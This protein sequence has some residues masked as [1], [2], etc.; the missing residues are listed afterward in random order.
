M[1]QPLSKNEQRWTLIVTILASGIVFLSGSIVNVALPAIGQSLDSGLSGLQWVVDGYL[2][3][4]SSLLIMGGTL[5][6]RFGR[7]QICLIGLVGFG[8]ALTLC[9]L[10]PSINWLIAARAFQGISGALLVPQS[11]SIIR[12]N[13]EDAEKRG[14]AIG[15]WSGWTGI[16]TVIGPLV[17][18]ALVS[19]L[20][21]RWAFLINL[22]LIILTI[23]LMI[24]FVPEKKVETSPQKLDWFGALLTTIGLGGLTFGLIEGPTLGWTNGWVLSGLIGG[25]IMLI[26]FPLFESRIKNPLLPLSLFKSRNF[27]G[28]NLT[29]F[30]VYAA[31]QG[32]TFILI[33]YV[34]N[35]MGYSPLQAGLITAPISLILLLLSSF[36]GK[37]SNQHGPRLFMTFGPILSGIGL[38]LLT[39]LNPDSNI[40]LELIPAVVVFG[41]GLSGTVA[42]LT[43]T[44]MSNAPGKHSS[45]AAAFNN[46]V[47]RVAALL[48]IATL[49]AIL[50]IG[51]TQRLNQQLPALDLSSAAEQQLRE[52]SQDPSGRIDQNLLPPEAYQAYKT[53]FTKGFQQAMTVAA[54]LT[55]IGG[56]IA[57]ITIRNKVQNNHVK[58]KGQ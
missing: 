12:V 1:D 50:S 7:R 24:K 16:A 36:F 32:S 34:Q 19:L 35:V 53:A 46:M 58:T 17:G 39:R 38:V 8:L 40:W 29:T 49:G 13:F 18:G 52:L 25:A 10:S 22:P 6:D 4:L 2:L 15:S 44:V 11:L 55:F 47:S 45:V 51:F 9:A 43:D 54:G 37:L 56:G 28:A 33:L 20:S 30:A 5:G 42:P 3:T 23:W 41:L 31:L 21:W 57:F 26:L 48:A 27:S 14:E